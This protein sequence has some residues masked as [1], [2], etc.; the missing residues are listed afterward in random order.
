MPDGIP[1]QSKDSRG[2]FMLPQAPED[3]GYYV[4]GTPVRGAGQ[5][6]H[7]ALLSVLFWVEREWQAVD[8][9][10]FG[11]GNISQAGGPAY[12]KCSGQ[13]ISDTTIDSF[14]AMFRS[15]TVGGRLPRTEFSRSQL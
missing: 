3:A 6:G 11:V 9:R 4:Y 2:Y 7:P 1:I 5:Y 14:A 8:H 10:K 15:K 12:P 13:V